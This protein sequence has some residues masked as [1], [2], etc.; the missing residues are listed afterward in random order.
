MGDNWK[1]ILKVTEKCVR[2]TWENCQ[3]SGKVSENIAQGGPKSCYQGMK[4]K[5]P[6]KSVCRFFYYLCISFLLI[7]SL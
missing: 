2:T 3:E 1:K 4:V 6:E 7:L 5:F